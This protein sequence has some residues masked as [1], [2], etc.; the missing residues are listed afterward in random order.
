M[1]TAADIEE[2]IRPSSLAAIELC[3]GRPTMEA[4]AVAM[5]PLLRDMCS[6]PARQGTL[7]HEVLAG[8]GR[9]AFAGDWSRA[10]A[11]VAGIEGRMAHLSGW[12]KDGVRACLAYLCA[13]VATNVRRFA[14]VD[15]LEEIRLDGA[16]IDIPRGGTADLVLLCYDAA[17]VLSL[18]VVADWKLGF[19]SQGEAA[20]HLQLGGYAVMAHDRWRPRLGVEVH[21][22]AGR[23]HEFTSA[24][25]DAPTVAGVRARLKA[26]GAAARVAAP[27]LRPC[28]KACRYC[29]ALLFCR[30]V[31]DLIMD[32]RDQLALFGFD[33]AGR[34]DLQ[35]AAALAKR[36]AQDADAVLKA[37]REA[38]ADRV[39]RATFTN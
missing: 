18:V 36:F 22:A 8:V 33:P 17:G 19:V 29:R 26:A 16:G 5:I 13:L 35:D 11:I 38:E 27:E 37:A 7:G 3:P 28:L 12:T 10:Q 32:A 24:H 34:L 30:P 20:D 14:R 1:I 39:S 21:L 23:R 9:D 6:E 31:R 15:V 25:Y 4:R 2:F